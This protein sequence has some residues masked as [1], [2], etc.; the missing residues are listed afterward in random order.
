MVFLS[1]D[2]NEHKE[3]KHNIKLI[4]A[5]SEIIKDVIQKYIK[6]IGFKEQRAGYGI[7]SV[8][9]EEGFNINVYLDKE[10]GFIYDDNKKM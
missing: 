8:M 7:D 10:N 6:G 1:D 5:I 4:V 9:T 3:K 2:T